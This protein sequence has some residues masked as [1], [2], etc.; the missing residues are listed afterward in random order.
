MKNK[1]KFF[2]SKFSILLSFLF[3]FQLILF[4]TNNIAFANTLTSTP[5]ISY[6]VNGETNVGNTIEIVINVLNV[7]DLYGGSVDFLYDP[8]ILEVQ[9]INNG[10]VFGSNSVLT[11]LGANGKI[12]NGQ[13]SFAISLK[14]DKSGVN[15][16]GTLAVIKAKVL[17]EGIVKLNTTP[18]NE[19][20]DL[21][22]N[23]IRVKLSNSN[24][25]SI[26]YTANNK[27]IALANNSL[28]IASID[29][30][31]VSPQAINSTIRVSPRATGNGT[32][33]YK[34]WIHDGYAWT[35]PQDFSSKSYFDW[36]PSTAGTYRIW[37]DVKDSSGNIVS[38]EISYV[39]NDNL[40]AISSIDTDRVSPQAINS[41]IRVSPRATGDGSLTYK[42]W[43]YDGYSWTVPQD[44]SSNSYFDWTPST[45]GTYRIWIDVK[46]SSDNI[47]SKEIS[48]VINDNLLSISSID[49]DKI[50]PQAINSTIRVSPRA[51]GNGTLTYKFWIYDGYSWTV[52]QD[53]SSNSYFDWTPSKAGT[54]R[55]WVDVKDSS[56]NIVSKEISY[57]IN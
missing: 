45:A 22:S 40:L 14:G 42:F 16:N 44:F 19:A 26:E 6:T 29:T 7:T 1:F 47:V 3:F 18:S 46:D 27:D 23:T 8:S 55:I 2:K 12:N 13:A 56:G 10:N 30:D 21:S 32:L 35:V 24:S 54:Y 9:S 39:I 34:F 38:K 50:S 37:V 15:S 17:K 57:I 49:T 11:P 25:S 4:N 48:Y 52:P 36:T 51:T 33:T 20:L 28:N 41:T 5:S 31:K 43:I 53:F